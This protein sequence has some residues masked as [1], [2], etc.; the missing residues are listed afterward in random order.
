[1]CSKGRSFTFSLAVLL[2][3]LLAGC[4]SQPRSTYPVLAQTVESDAD[5]DCKGFDDELLK[6]NAIRD[7]IF[8]EH[9]DVISDAYW[10][11]ALDV[12]TEPI[13]GVLFGIIRGLST[14]KASKTYLEAAAA[15]GLRMEQ[16]LVYK[17]QSN[18]PSG[19][20]GDPS[21]SDSIVLIKLQD[22]ESQLR[23]ESITQ[24]QYI[25]ERRMLLDDLR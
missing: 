18:C 22:L 17:E 20:T 11:T 6:A 8:E 21:L 5:M 15:A 24:K 3:A 25:S 2:L 16:M 19:L 12:A 7:A 1:M 23:Q 9:G 4:G 13:S 10:G 14:S